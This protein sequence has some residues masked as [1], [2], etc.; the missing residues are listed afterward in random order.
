MD[1]RTALLFYLCLIIGFA[2]HEWAH[3][4]VADKLGDYTARAL[5]RVTLNP[6]AHMD[7]IGSVAF[8][9]IC[10][11]LL[12]GQFLFA[13]GKPV[14]VNLGNFEPSRRRRCDILITLAGPASNLCLALLGAILGG[15]ASRFDPRL[16]ELAG[17]FISVNIMLAVFNLIPIPPL[18]GS[19]VFRYI[20]GMSEHTFVQFARWGFLILILLI[21][22]PATRS[23]LITTFEIFLTPFYVLMLLIS[24]Q[25]PPTQ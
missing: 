7:P 15:I 6:I 20:I 17:T 2:I 23:I 14:P 9:L 5:G 10:L 19:R 4:F 12:G 18:D 25:P 3:A 11:F 24:G 22:I 13:W 1:L 16:M 8:P 21:N